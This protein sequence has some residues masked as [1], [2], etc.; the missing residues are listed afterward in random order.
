VRA[1]SVFRVVLLFVV[2]FMSASKV[3]VSPS[4]SH[5]V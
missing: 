5:A 3:R 1:R 2:D 4:T